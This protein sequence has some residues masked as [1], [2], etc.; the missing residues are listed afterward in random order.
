MCEDFEKG[1]VQEDCGFTLP[2]DMIDQWAFEVSISQ[3]G[4]I[5]PSQAMIGGP[6]VLEVSV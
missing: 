5:C 1:K 2:P 6:P 4:L 3:G